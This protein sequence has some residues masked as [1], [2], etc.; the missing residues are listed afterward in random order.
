[1]TSK[2]MMGL[3]VDIAVVVEDTL[4]NLE[5]VEDVAEDVVEDAVVTMVGGAVEVEGNGIERTV[6][7]VICISMLNLPVF[8]LPIWRV[9]LPID[10][11]Q[12]SV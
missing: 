5:A 1:M 4:V 6:K 8:P 2:C 11:V 7:T 12:C 10:V 3:T 9:R